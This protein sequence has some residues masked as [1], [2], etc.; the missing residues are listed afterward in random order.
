MSNLSSKASIERADAIVANLK[1]AL[2]ATQV[3]KRNLDAALELLTHKDEP[4]YN[5]DTTQNLRG[6]E[7]IIQVAL[8]GELSAWEGYAAARK[9]H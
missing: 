9:S 7:S 2:E 5:G 6:T 4:K 1:A 3:A 8:I